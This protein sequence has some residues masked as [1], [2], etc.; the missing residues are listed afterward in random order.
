MT[1]PNADERLDLRPLSSTRDVGLEERV[2]GAVMTRVRAAET[3]AHPSIV[4]EIVRLRWGALTAAAAATVAAVV[5]G[6]GQP[7]VSVGDPGVAQAIGVTPD[8]IEWIESEGP[9]S[10]EQLI[11][12]YGSP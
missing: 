3:A 1:E 7:P 11:V 12:R 2:I 6:V 5:M 10:L 9:P 4:H 8:W